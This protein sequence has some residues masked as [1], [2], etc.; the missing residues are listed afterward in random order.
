MKKIAKD[1]EVSM[2]RRMANI[3]IGC[4]ALLLCACGSAST[5]VDAP[6]QDIR[7]PAY[8]IALHIP[9]GWIVLQQHTQPDAGTP[10]TV[11]IGRYNVA[12][13]ATNSS[14][15]FQVVKAS[16]PGIA[17][18]IAGLPHS[19]QYQRTQING[20]VAYMS[21]SQTYFVAPP[22]PGAGGPPPVA[23]PGAPGTLTHIDYALPT[24]TY[25]YSWYTEAVAGDKATADLAAM[26]QSVQ[27]LP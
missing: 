23:T 19:A 10:Y 2:S 17:Q 3:W 16:S 5:S 11:I 20:R 26:S 12:P 15:N 22:T 1:E 25:L 21:P 24:A 7:Q 13:G 4:M 14:L 18:F 6:A 8:H 9:A 27:V